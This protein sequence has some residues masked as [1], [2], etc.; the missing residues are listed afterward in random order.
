MVRQLPAKPIVCA[1]A[2]FDP[3]GLRADRRFRLETL[4]T[5]LADLRDAGVSDICLAGAI[6]RPVVD[7]AAIDAATLPLI[8][9][10]QHALM[11]GDD[12]ALRG[13]IAIFEQAGFNVRAAHEIAPGLLPES[14]CATIHQPD[15]RNRDDVERAETIVAAMSAADVGQ[16]CV[17][18]AGQALAIEGVYGT[19]WMLRSLK[20]RPAGESGG[21]LFKAPKPDQDRRAD[22]PT[23]GVDTI[24][25]A[26]EAGLDG[27]VIEAG[28]VIVL[29]QAGVLSESDEAGLFLWVRDRAD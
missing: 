22:L 14:G 11:Q 26:A 10:L 17:V 24:R 13:V 19:D 29:N 12:G 15:Q 4:G 2:G 28:G 21:I 5:L 1:L 23:I 8:P 20:D 3:E 18:M 7:P 25:S 16:C 27:I 9:V 6:R